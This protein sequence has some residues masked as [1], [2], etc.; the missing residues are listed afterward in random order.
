MSLTGCEKED[1][2]DG[3]TFDAAFVAAEADKGNLGPLKAL[4]DACHAEVK[5]RGRRDKVCKVLDD[6]G[7]L[8]K[9]LNI[10][11]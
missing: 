5:S 8:L 1:A 3:T 6:V 11:F 4:V 9:P 2:H 7:P 10:R